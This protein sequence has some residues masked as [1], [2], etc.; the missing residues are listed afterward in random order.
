MSASKAHPEMGS[1]PLII[2]FAPN[3]MVPTRE[4]SPH[5]PLQPDEIVRDVRDAAKIGI[6]MVHVHARDTDGRSTGKRD[7]YA[8]IISG[9]REHHPDLIICVSC[10]GRNNVDLGQRIDVLTLENELRPDMASLTLSS[11]NFPG[12]ASLND[13]DAIQSLAKHMME[14]GIVPEFEVF[15]LGMANYA[16][17]LVRSLKL[18]GWH[19]ANIILGNIATAQADLLSIAAITN[20]LP[21]MTLWSLGGIG[22][23]QLPV[24]ALATA[25]A[26]GVRVGLEDNLWMDRKRTKLASN[27]EMIERIHQLAALA[28]RSVMASSELRSFLGLRAS[29]EYGR[30]DP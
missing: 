29:N 24:T 6:T 22:N 9:I 25:V 16:R 19:Y 5:V 28:D 10:S 7:V 8:R 15:D 13:P 3:G 27:L 2:N 12:Q 23:S 30:A 18:N 21:D 14:R 17:Y 11:L 26:P 20:A 1:S 4:M